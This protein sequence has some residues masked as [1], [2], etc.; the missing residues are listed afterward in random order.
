MDKDIGPCVGRFKKWFYDR[1]RG[2][3][4]EFTF[5]GCEGNGNRFSSSDECESVCLLRYFF[6]LG[7]FLHHSVFLRNMLFIYA[8]RS[9]N[10]A[11]RTLQPPNLPFASLTQDLFLCQLRSNLAFI[12]N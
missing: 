4:N 11:A 12:I 10:R 7:D 9:P 5:G 1:K 6:P 3:C 2:A 8:E